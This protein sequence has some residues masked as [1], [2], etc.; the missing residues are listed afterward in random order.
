MTIMIFGDLGECL[1]ILSE[2]SK[3]FVVLDTAPALGSAWPWGT[4][5]H[6]SA[7]E[8]TLVLN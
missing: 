5:E 4:G 2:A 6:S 1:L 8:N 3:V 7:P